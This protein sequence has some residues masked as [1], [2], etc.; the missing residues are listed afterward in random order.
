MAEFPGM[1]TVRMRDRP[2]QVYRDDLCV[3]GSDAAGPSAARELPDNLAEMKSREWVFPGENRDEPLTDGALRR[4]STKAR[5]L[6]GIVADTRLHDLRN[7]HDQHAVMNG[8]S[9]R[10]AG[11]LFGHERA[12]P[13]TEASIWTIQH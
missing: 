13:P 12:P 6:A 9:L 3:A 8:E 5:D 4:F 11:R 7:A 2:A 1:K 10:V